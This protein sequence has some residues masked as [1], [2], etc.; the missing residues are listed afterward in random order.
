MLDW[1]LD[2]AVIDSDEWNTLDSIARDMGI[3]AERT[4]KGPSGL[5]QLHP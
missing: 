3:N 1:V 4:R 5:L 2:D